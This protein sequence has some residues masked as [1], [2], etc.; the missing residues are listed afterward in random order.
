MSLTLSIPKLNLPVLYL[1]D[2]N[3]L[4]NL[5]FKHIKKQKSFLY[6]QP[7]L[8]MDSGSPAALICFA[9][10]VSSFQPPIICEVSIRVVLV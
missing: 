8:N 1:V 10:S 3:P 5:Y 4:S 9:A 2:F 6:S 7:K